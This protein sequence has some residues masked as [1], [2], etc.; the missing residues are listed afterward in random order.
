MMDKRV[1]IELV[2]GPAFLIGNALGGIFAG[3]ILASLATGACMLLRWRWDR[4]LPWLAIAVLVLTIVLVGVGL[5]VEDTRFVKMTNTIGSVAFAAVIALGALLRPSLLRRTLGP[6]IHMAD[7]G[8][9]AMHAVWIG[10]AL[11]R[12]AVNEVVW[13]RISDATWAIYNGVSDILW[14]GLLF[15]AT[16]VVAYLWWDETTEQRS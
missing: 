11:M 6:T 3:A 7:K 1:L 2:P 14:F 15:G 5:A 10:V 13:R 8:W 4:S 9:Q 16:W 12:G